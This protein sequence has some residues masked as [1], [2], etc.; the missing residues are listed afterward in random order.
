MPPAA[1]AWT[2]PLATVEVSASTV[3]LP[4]A[5]TRV[6]TMT[7]TVT[8]ESEPLA[9]HRLVPMLESVT[10]LPTTLSTWKVPLKPVASSIVMSAP[11]VT[12]VP[13]QPPAR[14]IVSC[15]EPDPFVK[16]SDAFW[17]FDPM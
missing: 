10:T 13:A 14:V 2:D 11:A 4:V 6:G 9:A 5:T 15:V 8:D 12:F 3:T 16:V 7:M 17:S 1:F